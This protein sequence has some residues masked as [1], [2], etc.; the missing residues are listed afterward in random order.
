MAAL[1]WRACIKRRARDEA[2]QQDIFCDLLLF[3]CQLG[4][5]HLFTLFKSCSTARWDKEY[6]GYNAAKAL[7]N[8]LVLYGGCYEW[9]YIGYHTVYCCDCCSEIGSVFRTDLRN[10]Y[11]HQY[12]CEEEEAN[13]EKLNRILESLV[14]FLGVVQSL[15]SNEQ[16]VC[17]FNM[18]TMEQFGMFYGAITPVD[19]NELLIGSVPGTERTVMH[20]QLI[21]LC[22]GL[23][24]CGKEV[25]VIH[26]ILDW[27][28]N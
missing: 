17:F 2:C 23:V 14:S 18:L 28:R 22:Y 5:L 12:T 4:G 21:S 3:D 16:G 1:S 25:F 26:D 11:P 13:E 24:I 6:I 20:L 19:R 8:A 15:H 9:F 7:K 10:Q 27:Y